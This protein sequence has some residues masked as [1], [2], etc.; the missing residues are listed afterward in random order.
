MPTQASKLSVTYLCQQGGH[1]HRCCRGPGKQGPPL[2]QAAHRLQLLQPALLQAPCLQQALLPAHSG[3]RQNLN[4]SGKCRRGGGARGESEQV[5]ER[6][7]AQQV[8]NRVDN[9]YRAVITNAHLSHACAHTNRQAVRHLPLS[10]GGPPSPLLP[11]TW[12][13]GAAVAAGCPSATA[14]AASSVAGPLSA[15]SAAAG[16]LGKASEP[17]QERHVQEWGRG[18]WRVRAGQREAASTASR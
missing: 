9:N 16:S 14:V 15:A 1:R 12:K 3:R 8:G 6:Q 18:A 17:E 7:Q 2:L 5:R 13:A 10:A 11:G 4:K